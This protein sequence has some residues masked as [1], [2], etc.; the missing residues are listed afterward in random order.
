MF[1]VKKYV[2]ETYSSANKLMI[3][4]DG[5]YR[6]ICRLSKN[7]YHFTIRSKTESK[8]EWGGKRASKVIE[9]AEIEIEQLNDTKLEDE[10]IDK[11]SH[12]ER[13]TLIFKC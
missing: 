13:E 7:K 10:S 6:I 11:A 2:E 5:S 12:Y 9:G 4:P 8:F 1:L 3:Q